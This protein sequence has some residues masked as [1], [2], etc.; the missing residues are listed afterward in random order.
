MAAVTV[1]TAAPG[2]TLRVVAGDAGVQSIGFSSAAPAAD[3]HPHLDEA[4]RQLRDYFAGE[5]WR[6]DLP[7]DFNGTPFQ[8]RVWRALL[9][10]P[11]GE[12]RSYRHIAES[13]GAPAAVRA[14]GAANG[15][16][17][18]AIVVPCH[19]IIGSSGKLTGYGGGLP[20]KKLL[21]ELEAKY[22]WRSRETSTG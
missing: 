4:V 3:S 14:V 13:I 10:V 1:F 22:A 7:L 20:N 15:A 21:L 16:N 17:P 8:M 5:R 6:F 12:T 2:L 19:R 11:Y 18:I 9:Q